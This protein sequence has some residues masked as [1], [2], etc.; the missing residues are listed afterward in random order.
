MFCFGIFVALT[1]ILMAGLLD[2]VM[3]R[4]IGVPAKRRVARWSLTDGDE[5]RHGEHF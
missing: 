3:R 1:T 5:A 2:Q 4:T